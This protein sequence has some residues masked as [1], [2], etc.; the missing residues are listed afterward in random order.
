MA[1]IDVKSNR[2]Q[3]IGKIIS[4]VFFLFVLVIFI[5]RFPTA[6]GMGLMIFAL[7]ISSSLFFV[8]TVF[9]LQ[10]LFLPVGI[11]IDKST[12]QLTIRFLCNKPKHINLNA[13]ESFNSTKI[14]TKSTTYEGLIVH[15]TDKEII[16]LSNFNLK[17]FK[18][19]MT[20]L[21]DSKIPFN[22]N[23]KFR[24]LSYYRQYLG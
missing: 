15:L 11:F 17:D 7:I 10:F 19:V 13:I 1:T 16:L 20:Y 5:L 23:E 9:I 4:F 14:L 6:K 3:I 18:P 12:Q 21:E 8:E 2:F 24:A 22:G